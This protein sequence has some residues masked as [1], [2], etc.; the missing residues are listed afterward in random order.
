MLIQLRRPRMNCPNNW[1]ATIE[2]LEEYV[3]RVRIMKVMQECPL[4]GWVKYN[5]DG[6]RGNPGTNSYAF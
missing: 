5:T 6:A 2:M 3:S 4:E 1:P